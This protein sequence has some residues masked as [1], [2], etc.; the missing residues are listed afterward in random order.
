[1]TTARR[2]GQHLLMPARRLYF[3][4]DVVEESPR[5]TY[6]PQRN[7]KNTGVYACCQ[8]TP[9]SQDNEHYSPPCNSA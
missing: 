1:M 3:S 2:I 6:I 5:L 8:S 4:L 7:S 9:T